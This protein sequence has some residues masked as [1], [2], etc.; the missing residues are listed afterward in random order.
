MIKKSEAATEGVI[1]QILQENVCWN[2]FLIK[3]QT[4]R[5]ATL[6]K[7]A[8]NTVFSCKICKKI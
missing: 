2:I 8:S 6:L 7:R 4:L 3:L 5:P 1:L